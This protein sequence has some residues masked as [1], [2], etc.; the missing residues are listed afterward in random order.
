VLASALHQ[1]AS[2]SRGAREGGTERDAREALQLLDALVRDYP[3]E[4]AVRRQRGMTANLLTLLLHDEQRWSESRAL[5]E[6][7]C[8]DQ[9]FVLRL[10]A[11]D[12]FA[13]T[14]LGFHLMSLAV[15]L[16]ELGDWPAL[17]KVA[18]ELASLGGAN[19][20]GRG[21]RDLLR[22]AAAM[23]A[24]EHAALHT[25]V[26]D[27]LAA[28]RQQGLRITANDPLYAPLRDDPRFQALLG[29]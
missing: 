24:S 9:R 8:A 7:A 20:L 10:D 21:A 15:D 25:E 14:Q 4:P 23:P 12:T 18:R 3:E 19:H 22:C 27:L 6:Q 1:R 29:K 17:A 26:L 13:Q 2:L 28:A 11:G 16:R 5:M